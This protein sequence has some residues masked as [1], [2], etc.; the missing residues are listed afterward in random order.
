MKAWI[1]RHRIEIFLVLLVIAISGPVIHEYKSQQA[2]RYVFTAAMWDDGTIKIDR[3]AEAEPPVLGVDRAVRDGHT[4]SDKAPLQPVLAVPF[5][6]SYRAVGGQPAIEAR[7]DEHL[8]HWWVTFWMATV[9]A[10][11]LAALTYRFGRGYLPETSLRASIALFFGSILLPFSMLL[12]G[13]MMGAL[14][15]FATFV[16]LAATLLSTRRLVFAGVVA[17][18]AVAS[19]YTAAIAVLVL[20]AYAA[21]RVRTRVLWFL[22]GGVPAALGL[23]WYHTVAFGSPLTHPYRFSAFK[24]VTEEA[25]GFFDNFSSLRLSHLIELFVDGRGFLL[26]SPLIIIGLIGLVGMVRETA[27]ETRAIA[28]TSVVMFGAYLLIPVFW[29][30]PWGGDSP[31]PR[32]M[33][34]AFPFLAIGVAAA[35]RRFGM[36]ARA[37]TLYGVLV[38]AAASFTDPL[39]SDEA[40]VGLGTW[41]NFLADGDIVPTVFTIALGP[42]GWVVHIGLAAWVGRALFLASRQPDPERELVAA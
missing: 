12:F 5:Y 38:M 13:H 28:L 25:R 29:G 1:A 17:G 42:L 34:P 6:A 30:N 19:E 41:L 18:A 32:Y 11:L 37:A 31:G 10:A 15:V 20:T 36:W 23:A 3:Y 14:L 7:Y 40:A 2:S 26:A 39:L 21:W 16:L 35:W 9:P 33:L 24:Q 27:G 22:L 8:G 4:Y